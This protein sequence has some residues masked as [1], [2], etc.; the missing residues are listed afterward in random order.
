[1]LGEVYNL[2]LE[3]KSM[4]RNLKEYAAREYLPINALTFTDRAYIQKEPYGVVC[5]LGTWNYP[6]VSTCKP[7]IG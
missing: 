7:V 1:M 2:Q 5:V 6:F 4:L 3:I